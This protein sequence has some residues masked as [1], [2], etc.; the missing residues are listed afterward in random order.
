M[1][2]QNFSSAA[3]QGLANEIAAS[4]VRADEH[5]ALLHPLPERSLGHRELIARRHL[6]R[7]PVGGGGIEIEVLAVDPAD[8]LSSGLPDLRWG[9]AGRNFSLSP[10][11]GSSVAWSISGGGDEVAVARGEGGTQ[12]VRESLDGIFGSDV[13]R[14][15]DGCSNQGRPPALPEQL[16]LRSGQASDLQ[17]EVEE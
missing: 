9:R 1:E 10:T 7:C 14:L 6:L 16:S 4:A 12:K 11:T 15:G 5:A 3:L 2:M 17:G 8:L 13:S